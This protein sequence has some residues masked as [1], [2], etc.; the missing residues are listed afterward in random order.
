MSWTVGLY[1]GES[2]A[3]IAAKQDEGAHLPFQRW[4]LPHTPLDKGIQKYLT[5]SGIDSVR[6]L[7]VATRLGRQMILRRLGQT[8][9]LLVTS[10]FE[11]WPE[12]NLPIK[13]PRFTIVPK[14][15]APPLANHLIFGL[16]E[17]I[18]AQGEV[19]KPLA[20]EEL[21]FLVAKLQMNKVDHVVLGLMHSTMNPEH[22]RKAETYLRERGFKVYPSYAVNGTGSE[23]PRWWHATLNA[24]LEPAFKDVLKQISRG[25]GEL[26]G[27]EPQVVLFRGDTAPHLDNWQAPLGSLFGAAQVFDQCRSEA[28]DAVLYL[29]LEEFFLLPANAKSQVDWMSDFGRVYLPHPETR[30]LHIQPTTLI[31]KSS[32]GCPNLTFEVGGFEPGPMCFGRGVKPLLFDILYLNDRLQGIEALRNHLTERM[33]GRIRE[34]LSAYARE[35]SN[36]SDF[37]SQD[38]CRW[39]EET[40]L[41]SLACEVRAHCQSKRLKLQGPLSPILGPLLAPRLPEL[42][43]TA[44]HAQNPPLAEFLVNSEVG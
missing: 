25:L 13:D 7:R 24:Y 6:Q 5:E 35:A 34:T 9:A 30:E 23:K 3:E 19:E 42:E 22:E 2:F 18:N 29:G 8:P 43:V 28:S 31:G 16:A 20:D 27:E 14:R 17:R 26:G 4:F 1:V 32:Y 15:A 38:I 33:A 44:F 12:M 36:R 37:L 39:I 41:N 21:E 11:D 10:G 40:A